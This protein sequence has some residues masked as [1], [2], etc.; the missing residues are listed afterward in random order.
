MW[1]TSRWDTI[2]LK[3]SWHTVSRFILIFGIF[4]IRFQPLIY[5]IIISS[6]IYITLISRSSRKCFPKFRYQLII[7]MIFVV[8]IAIDN[9]AQSKLPIMWRS[10]SS[11]LYSIKMTPLKFWSL[12]IFQYSGTSSFSVTLIQLGPPLLS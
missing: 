11:Y 10:L 1:P 5:L 12:V 4:L 3:I 7:E 2:S 6:S 9:T 8:A